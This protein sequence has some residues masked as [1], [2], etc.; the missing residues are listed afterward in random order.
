MK[1]QKIRGFTIVEL[2]VSLAI[3]AMLF[4]AVLALTGDA[5]QKA[6]D[7]Q[8]MSDVREISKALALYTVDTGSFPI[9]TTAI[10][11]TSDDAVSTALEAEGVISET[12]TDPTHPT[13]VYTY[14]SSSNGDT[15]IVSFCL[16]TNTIE[17]YSQGCGNTLTP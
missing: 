11:I 3:I 13:T 7:S 10:T 1:I 6:R 12:P 9:E 16:E 15:Y 8:R 2:L 14:Q 5:R 4:S 17:N